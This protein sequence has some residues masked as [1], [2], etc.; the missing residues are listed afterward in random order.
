MNSALAAIGKSLIL[1]GI[2]A[3][4]AYNYF[5]GSLSWTEL[6][7]IQAIAGIFYICL[8]CYEFLNASYKA[9]LPVKRYPYFTNSYFMFRALKVI[10]FLSFATML[11]LSGSRVQY[12]YPLCLI[13]AGTEGII[14]FFYYRKSLCFV[15]IYANYLL[16]VQNKFTKLFVSEIA[17]V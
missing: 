12:I 1:T 11:Y 3:L 14:T 15:T 2:L 5:L 17:L 8:S 7:A 10:F 13:I 6:L 4:T 16:L 9:S